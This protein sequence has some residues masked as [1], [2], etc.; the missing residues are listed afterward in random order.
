MDDILDI[1]SLSRVNK[2][3]KAMDRYFE[4]IQKRARNFGLSSFQR[5]KIVIDQT[6]ESVKRLSNALSNL[7]SRLYKI[8]RLTR[9]L[10]GIKIAVKC[11]CS[12]DC[13]KCKMKTCSKNGG[14]YWF[15]HS[16]IKQQN[17]MSTQQ[18]IQKNGKNN[19]VAIPNIPLGSKISSNLG[20][21]QISQSAASKNNEKQKIVIKKPVMDLM[22]F[23][24]FFNKPKD[25]VEALNKATK[26]YRAITLS[27]FAAMPTWLKNTKTW[28]DDVANQI[29]TSTVYTQAASIFSSTPSWLKTGLKGAAKYGGKAIGF[30]DLGFDI[31]EI[32]NAKGEEKY[33]LIGKLVAGK[34][35]KYFREILW[36]ASRFK[37][38]LC[39]SCISSCPWLYIWRNR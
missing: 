6:T 26:A 22:N 23:F 20:K 13:S 36:Y 32:L 11:S 24:K 21:S 2:E 15:N 8:N 18:K 12:K 14:S 17:K 39:R 5:Q 28:I 35:R 1:R 33:K 37:S 19:N 4:S 38:S 7:T 29:K 30:A 3:L 27:Q 34:N 31:S 10:S 16:L 25:F 9:D